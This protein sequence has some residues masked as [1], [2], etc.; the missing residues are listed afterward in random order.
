MHPVLLAELTADR[1]ARLLHQA[2][3]QRLLRRQRPGPRRLP[4]SRWRL[5]S[6]VARRPLVTP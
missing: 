2:A 3:S 5:Q 1:H 6:P 4:R